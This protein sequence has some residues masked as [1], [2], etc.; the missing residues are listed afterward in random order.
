MCRPLLYVVFQP[1]SLETSLERGK[2]HIQRQNVPFPVVAIVAE[3]YL[4]GLRSLFFL[5]A[6]GEFFCNRGF[7][8]ESASTVLSFFLPPTAVSDSDPEL[9]RRL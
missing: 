5:A 2:K 7:L 6:L 4:N 1:Q 8:G 3:W 9:K